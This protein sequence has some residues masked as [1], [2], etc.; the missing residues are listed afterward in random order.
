MIKVGIVYSIV[1]TPSRERQPKPKPF[2]AP[3]P[4]L[5]KRWPQFDT[6]VSGYVRFCGL[7]GPP[8][9]AQDVS[10]EEAPQGPRTRV[11]DSDANENW[12]QGTQ[13]P[14]R[15]G[16]RAAHRLGAARPIATIRRELPVVRHYQRL[17][18]QAE[19]RAVRARGRRA[20]DN[21]L[22]IN[23]APSGQPV[24]RF[25][26]SVGKRVG[27]A[28]VRNRLKRRLREVLVAL[29]VEGGWDIVVVARVGAANAE[30]RQLNASVHNL[31]KRLGANG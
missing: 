3:F 16:P 15:Q 29:N 25:G 24:T 6:T 4:T 26:L 13:P 17:R 19:F 14:S 9:A 31:A 2:Q 5:C 30:F 20:A 12:P 22:I 21:L 23:A 28:V 1:G 10:A 7:E 8:Y 11:P 18:R 27:N